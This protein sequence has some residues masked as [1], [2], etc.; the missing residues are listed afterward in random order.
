MKKR[1][2]R[3][4]QTITAQAASKLASTET[5]K[6]LVRPLRHYPHPMYRGFLSR[7]V[8]PKTIDDFPELLAQQERLRQ[9][10]DLQFNQLGPPTSNPNASF[11]F[12]NPVTQGNLNYDT[13]NHVTP[14]N[15]SNN[16]NGASGR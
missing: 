12:G 2:R 1:D 16:P 3:K 14:P 10:R 15:F 9:K 4:R 7:L 6:E 13:F 11:G 5:S 8:R